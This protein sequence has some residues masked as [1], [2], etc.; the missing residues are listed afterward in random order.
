MQL[1]LVWIFL[2]FWTAEPSTFKPPFADL[3]PG[4]VAV[5]PIFAL[6]LPSL[7]ANLATRAAFLPDGFATF[8]F[9]PSLALTL[10]LALTT[11][12]FLAGAGFLAAPAAPPAADGVLGFL[13]AAEAAAAV[14][15]VE[16]PITFLAAAGVGAGF[17]LEETPDAAD[18]EVLD[19]SAA[20]ACPL[21]PAAAGAPLAF[22]AAGFEPAF[23]I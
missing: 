19:L 10:D 11:P 7:L 1:T 9:P 20:R 22:L 2:A 17:L 16:A 5:A 23:A 21:L 14:V 8:F 13:A 18:F 4:L 12:A 3:A 15:V 6:F